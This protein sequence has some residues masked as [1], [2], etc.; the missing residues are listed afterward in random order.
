MCVIVVISSAMFPLP[1]AI[2]CVCLFDHVCM[3][4]IMLLGDFQRMVGVNVHVRKNL[5]SLEI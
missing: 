2:F 5:A 1:E 3:C 4:L